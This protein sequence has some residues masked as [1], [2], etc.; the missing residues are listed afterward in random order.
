MILA[1]F[2]MSLALTLGLPAVFSALFVLLLASHYEGW[3]KRRMAE[4]SER[5]KQLEQQLEREEAKDPDRTPAA[6]V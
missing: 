2:D 4:R 5:L 3:L 1:A 6:S